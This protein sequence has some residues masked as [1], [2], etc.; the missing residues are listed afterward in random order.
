MRQQAHHCGYVEQDKEKQ[1]K[2]AS[3]QTQN[4][5]RAYLQVMMDEHHRKK[6]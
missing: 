4:L 6:G 3:L 1:E 5:A 2:T